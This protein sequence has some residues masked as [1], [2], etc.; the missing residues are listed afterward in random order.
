MKWVVLLA[1]V[2]VVCL[3]AALL[4]GLLGG[5]MGRPTS[6]LRHEPLPED[7]LTDDDLAALELDVTARGYRMSQVDGVLDRL[8]LEL[9][10]RDE[11][12]AALQAELARR[13]A[14]VEQPAV[15]RPAEELPPA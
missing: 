14:R 12:V 2:V 11:E 8:R 5:G 3:V 9:R 6:T 15:D 13:A 4:L 7:R 10:S 1:G